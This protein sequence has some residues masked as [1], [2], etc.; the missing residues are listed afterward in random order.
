MA[1]IRLI[2]KAKWI[3]ITELKISEPDAH[4]YIEKQS[5]NQCVPQKRIA[6]NIIKTY[7]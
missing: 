2:N 6:E 3:L 7:T 4:H 5:I 1:E